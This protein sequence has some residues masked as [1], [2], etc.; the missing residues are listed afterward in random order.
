MCELF[1]LNSKSRIEINDYLTTF[2][3]HSE[4][5]YSGWG[6]ACF[7][8]N[9]VSLEKEPTK[10][11]ESQYLK[12]RLRHPLVIDNAIAHIRLATVGRMFYENTHP[13]VK[14]DNCGRCWTLAHNGTIFDFPDMDR[15]KAVQEG[16][17]DSE[18]ILYY[19]L[20]NVNS[21]QQRMGRPLNSD[22]RFHLLDSLIFT[23][24]PGNKINL[25]IWD[26]EYLYV[27]TNYANTLYFKEVAPDAKIFSTQP[28]DAANDWQPVPFL[29]LL[30]Y[31]DGTL[32]RS[33]EVDTVEYYTE[34]RDWEYKEYDYAGL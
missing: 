33:G 3:S 15:Y 29:R 5:H 18:R 10:A 34:T 1:G 30:A 11:S 17:S 23:L 20:D 7:Y 12:H 13:F 16:E 8:G 22:E 31:R 14:H 32:V 21:M 28:L 9:N 26:T 27:H 25:L 6:L 24:S 19:I 2:F 4:K